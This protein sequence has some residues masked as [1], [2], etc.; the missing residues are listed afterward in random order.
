MPIGEAHKTG[1]SFTGIME[2][3]LAEGKYKN[4]KSS[5]KPEIIFQNFS[6]EKDYKLLGKEFRLQAN[7]NKNVKKPVFHFT[8]NFSEKDNISKAIQ[9]DFLKKLMD[10]MKVKDNNYQYI[11]VRHNDKH[12][13]YHILVNRV[14]LDG[15]TLSDKNSKLRIGTAVDKIEK[16]LGLDNYLEKTRKFIYDPNSDKGYRVN[17]NLERNIKIKSNKDKQIGI[18]DKKDFIQLKVLRAIK[19]PNI[20]SLGLL[21]EKLLKDKIEFKYNLDSKNRLGVSFSYDG[22]AVKGTQIKIKGSVI[23]N[24]LL[25]NLN[26]FNLINTAQNKKED[27]QSLIRNLDETFRDLEKDYRNGVIPS[28]KDTFYRNNLILTQ[29]GKIKYNSVQVTINDFNGL[30]QKWD[31]EF[32]KAKKEHQESL[33]RY[34]RLMNTEPKKGLMGILLPSQIKYNADLAKEK[35]NAFKPKLDFQINIKSQGDLITLSLASKIDKIEDVKIEKKDSFQLEDDVKWKLQENYE[36]NLFK[37]K[38]NSL[39]NAFDEMIKSSSKQEDF[40]NQNKRK[41]K[42]SI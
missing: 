37:S 32:Y 22:I 4:E 28:L 3:I 39:Q 8:L 13:H 5:K 15:S 24:Q 12:P 33:E 23:K 38:D 25:L 16:E 29:N 18:R 7:E 40:E 17:D 34:N 19:D 6:F 27:F 2:Y 9:I 31:S 20:I 41:R 26:N 1:N 42:Y 14:G 30:K 10:E 11:V 21:K 36:D 35:Q